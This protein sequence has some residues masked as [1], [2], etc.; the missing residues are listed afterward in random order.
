MNARNNIFQILRQED[1]IKRKSK[2]LKESQQK[3]EN[4]KKDA[5]SFSFDISKYS[6][7]ADMVDEYDEFF[8]EVEKLNDQEKNGANDN[9]EKKKKKTK[10]KKKEDEYSDDSSE[11]DK[12]DADQPVQAHIVEKETKNNKAAST[13]NVTKKQNGS[14]NGINSLAKQKQLERK[15]KCKK[16]REKNKL[17][18]IL[19]E[20]AN[21]YNN[22]NGEKEANEGEDLLNGGESVEVAVPGSGNGGATPTGADANG[23]AVEK[24]DEGD[25]ED[26][27]KKKEKKKK[28]DKKKKE[29]KKQEE[30]NDSLKREELGEAAPGDAVVSAAANGEAG[31]PPPK[32]KTPI[33]VN[34]KLK[35]LMNMTA[36]K[37]KKREK[38][39]EIIAIVEREESIK[40]KQQDKI[41]QK[42]KQKLKMLQK[43]MQ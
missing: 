36:K 16:E 22:P 39:D 20:F 34:E 38:I 14:A 27:L 13:P 21:T 26:K 37:K 29:K 25:N 28:K 12:Q 10:K 42:E 3:K 18:N 1:K 31:T 35:M 15:K 30:L 6:S 32:E 11:E 5:S 7:W 24:Q 2:Q 9:K 4:E 17:E 19:L 8:Y 41:K 23:P 40:K 43:S 33:A